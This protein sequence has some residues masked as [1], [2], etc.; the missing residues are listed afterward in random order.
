MTNQM[1]QIQITPDPYAP[2]NLSQGITIGDLLFIS[3]QTSINGEGELLHSGDFMAQA[4][5]AFKNLD[6]VLKAGGSALDNVLKVTIFMKDMR[7]FEEIVA[8]REKYFTYPYPA[9]SIIEINGLFHPEALIEIEAIA[10]KNEK[11]VDPKN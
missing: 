6:N 5:L 4:E 8:L 2:F 9:D 11:F 3:G 7:Y 10:V 1:Q